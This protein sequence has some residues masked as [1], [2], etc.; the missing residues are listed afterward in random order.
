MR[1]VTQCINCG[2]R[3]LRDLCR[4]NNS[5]REI[6]QL[7]MELRSDELVHAVFSRGDH[8]SNK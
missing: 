4:K 7:L 2:S 8:R 1:N 3:V 5:T 6:R